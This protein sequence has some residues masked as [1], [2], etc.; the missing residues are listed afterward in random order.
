MP[1]PGRDRQAL[2]ILRERD[3]GPG[4]VL[5]SELL[6][7]S[8]WRSTPL[9]ALMP[10]LNLLPSPLLWER[11]SVRADNRLKAAGIDSA[12]ALARKTPTGVQNLPEIGAKTSEEIVQAA[13]GAWAAAHLEP[14]GAP[15]A[16]GD[17]LEELRTDPNLRETKLGE[18]LPGL[19]RL[20]E[21]I[22]LPQHLGVRAAN[23]LGRYG[24]G[25]LG[26]LATLTPS[27]ISALPHAGP[28][29]VREI[30]ALAM[31]EWAAT[32]LRNTG[33]SSENDRPKQSLAA[34]FEEVEAKPNFAVFRRRQLEAGSRPS[35][36][37]LAAELGISRQAVSQKE[38]AM[39]AQLMRSMRNAEWPV[40][41]AVEELH[42]CLGTVARPLEME[43]ALA[44]IDGDRD[45]PE[46]G[47]DHRRAL[48]IHLAGYR[49]GSEWVLG[50]DIESL[51]DVV[52]TAMAGS[53]TDSLDAVCRHLTALGVRKELQLP[54]VFSR[55]GFRIVDGELRAAA[56][57]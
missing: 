8:S 39:K 4:R 49:V 24:A 17:L 55:H 48:L 36:D 47:A 29:T 25:S 18:L 27:E 26:A 16:G 37:R 35:C 9:G 2:L 42:S 3:G 11:L 10:G 54:W 38:M 56:L 22:S 31:S 20:D 43:R 50:P 46:T 23:C 21:E 12:L 30:L 57:A 33:S 41:L 53:G 15:P 44:A 6:R 1:D 5:A 32:Y 28:R 45:G 7:R 14:I 19:D 51:T 52:L 40:R 34:A 13:L